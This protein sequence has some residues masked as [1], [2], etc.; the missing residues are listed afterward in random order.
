MVTPINAHKHAFTRADRSIGSHF[1]PCAAKVF[2]F[3]GNKTQ[4]ESRY[5]K[6]DEQR[7]MEGVK[8]AVKNKVKMLS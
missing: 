8:V 7:E 6:F 1:T 5:G 3:T 2:H 4:T